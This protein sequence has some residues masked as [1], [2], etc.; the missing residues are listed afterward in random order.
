[1]RQGCVFK[2]LGHLVAVQLLIWALLPGLLVDSLPLDVVEGAYWGR[3]W[4][5]GYYKH[6]PFPAW[7]L[8]LFHA[9]L[10]DIGPFLLSQLCIGRKGPISP[11]DA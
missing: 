3:E 8:H 9:S 1:M 10:G 4:Q 7:V 2:G 5:W 11:S 6:P